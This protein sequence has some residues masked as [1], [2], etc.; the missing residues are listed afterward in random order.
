MCGYEPVVRLKG[1]LECG[2]EANDGLKFLLVVMDATYEKMVATRIF[3][4]MAEG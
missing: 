4:A 2:E 1:E 3:K